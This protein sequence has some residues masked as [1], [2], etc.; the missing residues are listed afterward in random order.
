MSKL[1]PLFSGKNANDSKDLLNYLLQQFHIELNENISSKN[2]INYYQLDQRDQ[3]VMLK[4][5]MDD[6]PSKYNS[7]IAK[8][9]FG[10]TKGQSKCGICGTI[11]YNF[12]I[13][14]FLEFPLED[15][16]N[17]CF[18]LGM[19]PIKN[20]DGSNPNINLYECFEYEKRNIC[21]SGQNA[22]YCNF[23]GK[24]SGSY[25]CT[26]IHKGPKNL[27]LH[28]YRGKGGIYQCNVN[29][30]NILN[31]LN[32]V[33]DKTYTVYE[34]YAVIVHFGP[35]SMSGHF[36]AYCKHKDNNKWYLFN[37]GMIS[38]CKKEEE[39]KTGMPYIL[40]YRAIV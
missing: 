28:L 15:V 30:P 26:F 33:E 2:D 34:L 4:L 10:I 16:N 21:Q 40:F 20:P 19:R 6:I 18:N 7:I 13:V 9:F 38:L 37:D 5:L 24:S 23:C 14:N 1:N 11:I 12:Q 25:T 29:F 22:P 27:I 17:F 32:Y 3:N 35:S 31:L 8:I 39:Y 36:V